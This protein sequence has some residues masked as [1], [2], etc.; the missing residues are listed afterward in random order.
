M[1]VLQMRTLAEK[2]CLQRL[3]D[4]LELQDGGEIGRMQVQRLITLSWDINLSPQQLVLTHL[5]VRTNIL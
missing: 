1:W 2:C 5:C 4:C 3:G